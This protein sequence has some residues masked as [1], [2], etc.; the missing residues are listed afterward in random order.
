MERQMVKNSREDSN[1]WILLMEESC[2]L[3]EVDQ[4]QASFP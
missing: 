4:M 3:P 2:K 1:S